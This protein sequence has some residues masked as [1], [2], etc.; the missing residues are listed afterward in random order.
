MKVVNRMAVVRPAEVV[1]GPF[2]NRDGSKVVYPVS[3]RDINVWVSWSV[4]PGESF[5]ASHLHFWQLNYDTRLVEGG[6]NEDG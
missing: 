2:E 3:I 1:V 5:N 6:E 4:D